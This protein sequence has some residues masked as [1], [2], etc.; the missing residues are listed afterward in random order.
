MLTG[1]HDEKLL[2]YAL[3]AASILEAVSAGYIP[4]GFEAEDMGALRALM[5]KYGIEETSYKDT[6]AMLSK[7]EVQVS[8]RNFERITDLDKELE[9]IR[10][11]REMDM[12]RD[13][14]RRRRNRA[15]KER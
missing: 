4:D 13:R 14:T 12:E 15:S 7:T 6:A 9:N 8:A 3:E 2:H 10:E 1:K 5:D 11:R